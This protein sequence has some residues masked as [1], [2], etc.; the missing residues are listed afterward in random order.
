MGIAEGQAQVV[1][2]GEAVKGAVGSGGV[3]AVEAIV[4]SFPL[5]CVLVGVFVGDH[6]L[7]GRRVFWA[8]IEFGGLISLLVVGVLFV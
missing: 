2:G 5:V 6:V 4:I 8:R 1:R 3:S 7:V